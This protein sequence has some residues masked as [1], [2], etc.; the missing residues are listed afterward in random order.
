VSSRSA[1]VRTYRIEVRGQLDERWSAWLGGATI[2]V[3]GDPSTDPDAVGTTVVTASLDQA[4][5]RGV[6]NR[7]WD[8]NLTLLS[9]RRQGPPDEPASKEEP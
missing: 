6:L 1:E 7:L 3:H 2:A 8:L 4:G 5:L 9:V